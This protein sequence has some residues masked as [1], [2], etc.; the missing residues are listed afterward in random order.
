MS[1]QYLV[2]FENV[3][4][5]GLFGMGLLAPEDSVYLF[6]TSVTDKISL[7]CLDDVRA[8]VRVILV[9]P[10]KQS[11]DMHLGSFLGYLIGK[12]MDP[13]DRYV[14]VSRDT[15]YRGITD[16]WNDSF[17]IRDKVQCVYSISVPLTF[18]E[19]SC[20]DAVSITVSAEKAAV[21]DC[22]FDA[23]DSHG[24]ISRNGRPCMLVSE[25]CT[26][27]NNLPEYNNA[28]KRT[29]KRPMQYLK[30]EC[31]DILWVDS[32]LN[33]NWVYL[34]GSRTVAME[35]DAE[36]SR[37]VMQAKEVRQESI[38]EET[39]QDENIP[40]IMELG[41][42]SIDDESVPDEES[43][44]EEQAPVET[45]ETPQTEDEQEESDLLAC[46]HDCIL[47][48]DFERN[49]A[50]HIR[51]SVLRDELMAYPAFRTA[52]KESGMKPIAF[53]TQLF[54]DHIRIYR[55]KGVYWAAAGGE[56]VDSGAPDE[57][58]KD[59]AVEDR[60]KKFFE[61]AFASIRLRLTDAGLDQ[62]TAD[63]I[64]DIC[65]HSYTD[66]EPRKVIHNLLCQ[67]Y[68]TKIGAQY[69]RKADKY[70]HTT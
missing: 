25:L 66:T 4:E 5:S 20:S 70:M 21:R 65:L 1:V 34:L 33:Q 52:L 26:L 13:E 51:A 57:K 27:L 42:L 49:A 35:T 28:R 69:Y 36:E 44:G 30:E 32:K 14:I 22:I 48:I 24:F 11:L 67:R 55:E 56:Q 61:Q 47:N 15:D 41:D 8:W 10:G 29:G 16:F 68:G 53:I 3:H 60:Q 37:Q 59:P 31:R 40:D 45:A 6:H 64:A 12:E 17:R 54:L 23:F 46:A 38:P 18:G 50:G 58:K 63:D 39:V 9:P 7:S 19:S 2:D 43:A 62:S